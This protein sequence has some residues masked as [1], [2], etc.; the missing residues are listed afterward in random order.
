MLPTRIAKIALRIFATR[1][2]RVL[3]ASNGREVW[4][5]C[6]MELVRSTENGTI[7]PAKR[8]MKTMC[9]PDSGIIPIKAARISR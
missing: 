3:E 9:G 7:P 4:P 1:K 5:S 2:L 6:D 8:E